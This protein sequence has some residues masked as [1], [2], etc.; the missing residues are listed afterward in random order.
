M[1]SSGGQNFSA[2]RKSVRKSAFG[3]RDI[4]SMHIEKVVGSGMY[5]VVY[6]AV[7]KVSWKIMIHKSIY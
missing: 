4:H 5:G 7:D 1:T 2:S 3:T 6:K